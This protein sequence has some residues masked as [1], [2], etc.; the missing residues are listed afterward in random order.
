MTTKDIDVVNPNK[1]IYNKGD[2]V[3]FIYE[4]MEFDGAGRA[5]DIWKNV[6]LF[7]NDRML[8]HLLDTFSRTTL[9]SQVL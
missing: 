6:T 1:G 3:A 5:M 8:G 2:D 9:A 7:D 4:C